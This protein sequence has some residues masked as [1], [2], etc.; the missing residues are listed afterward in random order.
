M[1]LIDSV[2]LVMSSR[3]RRWLTPLELLSTQGFT[4]DVKHSYGK[5]VNSF[6]LRRLFEEQGFAMSIPKSSRR[7]MCHQAGNSMH[8]TISGMAFMYILT[9]I[10]MDPHVMSLQTF[11][12]R[13]DVSLAFASKPMSPKADLKRKRQED[14]AEQSA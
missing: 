14:Q 2:N 4:I 10:M 6:S 12:R 13:R 9:Q 1:T 7:A 11:A 3:H 5:A 8:V